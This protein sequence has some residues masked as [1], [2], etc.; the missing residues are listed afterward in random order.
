MTGEQREDYFRKGLSAHALQ[1]LWVLDDHLADRN[2]ASAYVPDY[3]CDS[4]G[5]PFGHVLQALDEL[6]LRGVIKTETLEDGNL[7]CIYQ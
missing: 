3:I 1:V 7:I 2:E 5:L 4:A 6:V